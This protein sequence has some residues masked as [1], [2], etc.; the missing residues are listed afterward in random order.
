MPDPK[1]SYDKYES[2]RFLPFTAREVVSPSGVKYWTIDFQYKYEVAVTDA[3]G[4]K[5]KDEKGKQIYTDVVDKMRVKHPYLTTK[6]GITYRK[7]S[8]SKG[9]DNDNS[10]TNAKDNKGANGENITREQYVALVKS[11]ADVKLKVSLPV[12][13]DVSRPDQRAL[14]G[15]NEDDDSIADENRV[16]GFYQRF[17]HDVVDRLYEIRGSI[18]PLSKV[19][20][21]EGLYSVFYDGG[22]IHYKTDP[23]TNR[24]IPGKAPS[25]FF[26]L[27]NYGKLGTF[28]RVETSFKYGKKKEDGSYDQL[29]WELLS[30]VLMTF[31][32]LVLMKGLMVASS[33]VY[34][35]DEV[36]EA[37]VKEIK[38]ANSGSSMADELEELAN[39]TT[40]MSIVENDINNLKRMHALTKLPQA[41]AAIVDAPPLA[42]VEAVPAIMPPPP[43]ERKIDIAAAISKAQTLPAGKSGSRETRDDDTTSH[44]TASDNEDD[45]SEDDRNSRLPSRRRG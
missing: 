33:T 39:D 34:F 2:E 18:A 27:Q 5:V 29:D 35:M 9:T 1:I 7:Q 23:K 15:D 25:R 21:K 26:A 44:K 12:T 8:K 22:P 20:S 11:E 32:P 24:T 41:S 31:S 17:Y 13:F 38:P 40:Q 14:V 3:K 43:V 28:S 42:E 45:D 36:T 30:N 37:I 4:E 19:K 10:D 16:T 6:K